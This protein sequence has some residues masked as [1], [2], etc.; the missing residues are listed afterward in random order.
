MKT[1]DRV[2]IEGTLLILKIKGK[3]LLRL[4]QGGINNNCWIFPGGSYDRELSGARELGVQCA[5]RETQE[6]TGITPLEPRLKA[7]IFFDNFKRIFPGKTEVASFDY[8]ALYFY[9]ENYN[10]ELKEISPDG[11]KQ[12]LFTYEEALNLP[13]HEGD[14]EILKALEKIPSNKVFEG[15]IVHNGSKLDLAVFQEI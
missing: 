4:E 3:Y 2:I 8:D 13:M 14:K 1:N 12:G 15:R 11:K 6:E 9:T 7:R 5:I 10:G